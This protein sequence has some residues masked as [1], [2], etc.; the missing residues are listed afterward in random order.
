MRI[1]LAR[2]GQTTANAEG[3][4]QGH[5]DYPLSALGEIQAEKLAGRLA[6]YR[7]QRLYTSDLTRSM[8]TARPA[9]KLL[10]LVP[11]PALVFREYS[12]GLL[13]GLS[14]PEIQEQYPQLY[15][16]LRR[17]LRSAPI[18]GQEPPPAFRR[19][20]QQGL[21]VL[22]DKNGLHTVA[23]IGHG[24]YLNALLVEFLGLDFE[25]PWPFPFSSAAI[26][27]LE[28]KDGARRLLTFNEQCHLEESDG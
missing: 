18:P 10:G 17:D 28:E 13:E 27:V 3:R 2:H 5:S 26:T 24:R 19:R 1:I 6:H 21:E 11:V 9:A 4:F 8:E 25:G 22:L 12:W 23:L 16:H 15:L 20:L 14:W 7:P